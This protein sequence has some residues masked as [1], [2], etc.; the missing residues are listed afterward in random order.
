MIVQIRVGHGDAMKLGG[1][2]FSHLQVSSCGRGSPR[3][4]ATAVA[5]V[6]GQRIDRCT[7]IAQRGSVIATEISVI[8]RQ[9][10]GM[11]RRGLARHEVE[12]LPVCRC[13]F[14]EIGLTQT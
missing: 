1:N 12:A 10:E 3:R 2:N 7:A 4:R 6:A 5:V 11:V 13:P 9:Q 14:P 8:I